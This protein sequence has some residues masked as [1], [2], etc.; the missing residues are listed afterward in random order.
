MSAVVGHCILRRHG[1]Y[2]P[3]ATLGLIL[4]LAIFM[5]LA[6]SVAAMLRLNDPTE[7]L[8]PQLAAFAF[9]T[10]ALFLVGAAGLQ[11]ARAIFNRRNRAP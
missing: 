2:P 8:T 5:I 1:R 4:A 3:P 10:V 9:N 11:L 7:A 6:M